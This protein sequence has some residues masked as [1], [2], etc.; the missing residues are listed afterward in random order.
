MKIGQVNSLLLDRFTAPG[1][2]LLDEEGNDVL[3]PGKYITDD[4]Q[5]GEM[6]DVFLYR[7]SEDRVVATTERPKIALHGFAYLE[8]SDVSLYGAFVDWGLEKEL[9]IPY[10]EQKVRMEEGSFYF[11]SLQIDDATDRLYGTTK[12]EK[13]IDKCPVDRYQEGDPVELL[14]WN[15]TD[16]GRKVLVDDQYQGLIFADSLD[17]ELFPGQRIQGYT[18]GVREDGK[19][20][21][22]LRKTGKYKRLDASDEL[23][24][25]LK[26]KGSLNLGDKSDPDDIRREL[27]MSKKTFKQAVGTLYKEQKIT[28]EPLRITLNTK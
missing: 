24:E 3:L 20:D 17:M 14:V 7:D 22:R 4:M 15:R 28:V 19:I 10:K 23:L 12:I 5:E 9:L 25:I 13:H 27:G 8:V 6:L 26:E 18:Y 2:Y 21:I 1:A 11:I 16:L